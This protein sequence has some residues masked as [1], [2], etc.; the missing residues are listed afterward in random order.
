MK[1]GLRR[2]EHAIGVVSEAMKEDWKGE[3]FGAELRDFDPANILGAK[4]LRH[5]DRNA[6][7]LLACMQTDFAEALKTMARPENVG[8]VAGTTFGSLFSQ[9]DFTR[10]YVRDGFRALNAMQ[11]P[12]MVINVPPSQANIWFSLT[13][14]STTIS[15][16]FT[17]GLDAVIFAADAI[18]VGRAECLIAG[19][20]ED[21]LS[22]L[23]ISFSRLGWSNDSGTL[24]PFNPSKP[25]TV[26]GEGAAF[27]RIA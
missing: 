26:L 21:F 8:L 22:Q 17:A 3:L 13:H 4:G 11:F 14:S 6:L 18:R 23:A 15:N 12:N 25:G 7:I 24:H 19:G 2:G 20:S 1:K 5:K 9:I 16:G 27:I 10:T